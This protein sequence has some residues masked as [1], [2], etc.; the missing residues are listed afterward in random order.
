MSGVVEGAYCLDEN[1]NEIYLKKDEMDLSYRHS[2]FQKEMIITKVVFSLEPGDK[3]VIF[4]K[5][6]ELIKRR[7]EKQPLEF[8]SAGSTFKRPEG[9][10]AGTLIEKSGLKGARCGGA[11]VS[12]KHAGFIIN[13]DNATAKDVKDL[14]I[15]VKD[16]VKNASG[17]LLE[18]E[19]IFVGRDAD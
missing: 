8:P 15:K 16:T 19:V 14:I 13:Y 11:M 7:K 18:P 5:M 3:E 9:N 6:D 2:V 4:E 1:F 12:E 17:V 10:Y